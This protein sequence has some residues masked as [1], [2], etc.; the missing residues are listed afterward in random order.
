MLIFSFAIL[1]IFAKPMVGIQKKATRRKT[2]RM[3]ERSLDNFIVMQKVGL[4]I[5]GVGTK[6][7][8][9]I[10]D[11]LGSKDSSN[12]SKYQEKVLRILIIPRYLQG[13]GKERFPPTPNAGIG[14]Y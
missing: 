1:T 4:L 5:R 14:K 2:K 12:Q 13:Y 6:K 9:L 7:S 8:M 11:Q 3:E 10:S